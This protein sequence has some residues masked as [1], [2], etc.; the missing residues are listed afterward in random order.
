MR[1]RTR[2]PLIG[3]ARRMTPEQRRAYLGI[4]APRDPRALPNRFR[5]SSDSLT[6]V[7]E[8]RGI[9]LRTLQQAVRKGQVWAVKFRG[10]WRIPYRDLNA[11]QRKYLGWEAS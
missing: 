10:T 6:G 11:W 2:R 8:I 4:G 5:H 1:P 9:P 3:W 7:A